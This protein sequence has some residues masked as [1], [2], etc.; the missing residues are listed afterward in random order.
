MSLSADRNLLFGIIALQ[1]QLINREQLLTG[2]QDWSFDKS[3]PLAE[4]LVLK[5][6]L[7]P[8]QRSR[9]DLLVNANLELHDNDINQSMAQVSSLATSLHS[10]LEK[11]GDADLNGTLAHLTDLPNETSAFT[12]RFKPSEP[13]AEK[14]QRFKVLRHHASGG[15][16]DVSVAEDQELHREVA[17]KEIQADK[18]DQPELRMRFIREAEITGGLEH[19]GIVPVYGLGAYPDGR[20]YYAMRF[21]RGDSLDKAIHR[22]HEAQNDPANKLTTTEIN[23]RLRR[24]LQRFI[25]VCEAMDY[26][27]SRGVL[28]RDLKPGNI[29]LGRYG[30]TLVVDWGLAKL[31]SDLPA[32]PEPLDNSGVG[33]EFSRMDTPGPLEPSENTDSNDLTK[34]GRAM[35]TLAYMSSEQAQ[36]RLDLLGAKS[37]VFGLGAILFEILTNRAPYVSTKRK[38]M[39]RDLEL[40]NLAVTGMVPS[41]RSINSKIPKPLDAICLKALA[42]EQADRYDTAKDLADDL[43]RYLADEPVLAKRDTLVERIGRTVRRHRGSFLAGTAALLM[44]T[45]GTVFG[46]LAINDAKNSA[47]ASEQEALDQKKRADQKSEEANKLAQEEHAARIENERL[48]EE[49]TRRLARFYVATGTNIKEKGDLWGA[50]N[51]YVKAWNEDP[52]QANDVAHRLRIGTTLQEAPSLAAAFFHKDPVYDAVL[53]KNGKRL[54]TLP[55]SSRAWLYD[56]EKQSAITTLDHTGIVLAAAFNHDDT[57]LVTASVDGV[58]RFWN[59]ET[60]QK[61]GES[62]AFDAAIHSLD[63]HDSKNLITLVTQKGGPYL[64]DYDKKTKTTF[65]APLT[66]IGFNAHFLKGKD[67]VVATAGNRCGLWDATQ[68][69]PIGK[70]YDYIVNETADTATRNTFPKRDKIGTA[71]SPDGKIIVDSGKPG[72]P[73]TLRFL[74]ES[75]RV[76]ELPQLFTSCN[77]FSP[78]GSKFAYTAGNQIG[79]YDLKTNVMAYLDHPRMTLQLAWHPT[80]PLLATVG[81]GGEVRV[82]DVTRKETLGPT[83]KNAISTSRIKFSSDGQ[84]LLVSDIDGGVRL[85]KP[86]SQQQ[87]LAVATNP[88]VLQAPDFDAVAEYLDDKLYTAIEYKDQTIIFRDQL[89]GKAIQLPQSAL[90]ENLRSPLTVEKYWGAS[91]DKQRIAVTFADAEKSTLL[92]DLRNSQQ[93]KVIPLKNV[94]LAHLQFSHSG[95]WVIARDRNY[96]LHLINTATGHTK[97]SLV[98]SDD[99]QHVRSFHECVISPDDRQLA[100]SIGSSVQICSIEPLRKTG[101]CTHNYDVQNVTFSRDSTL[102][103]TASSDKTARVWSMDGEPQSPQFQHDFIVNRAILSPDCKFLTTT[104][105][106]KLRVW[107]VDTGDLLFGPISSPVPGYYDGLATLYTLNGQ[108]LEL[109]TFPLNKQDAS[110]YAE[111][112][113]SHSVD[114]LAGFSMVTRNKFTSQHVE[115]SRFSAQFHDKTFVPE[116]IQ[117]S[118]FVID[119]K[120]T[121]EPSAAQKYLG[122]IVT[123]RGKIVR[124]GSTK[125]LSF[126]NFG[127]SNDGFTAVIYEEVYEALGGKPAELFANK[128]VYIVGLVRPFRGK[129]EIMIRDAS[130]IRI[131]ESIPL[132]FENS[133]KLPLVNYQKIREHV[134]QEVAVEFTVMETGNI[135]HIC[136]LNVDS[137]RE[138][139]VPVFSGTFK[140]IPG[141]SKPEEYYLNKKVRVTGKVTLY[142]ERPQ[143][144][145]HDLRQINIVG[146]SETI[147]AAKSPDAAAGLIDLKKARDH[148]GKEVAVEFTV[149][150]TGNT[151]K[152]CF[153][154]NEDDK[155]FTVPLFS[156]T[157]KSVPGGSK[158]EDFYLKKKL[159]VTGKITLYKEKPQIEVHDLSQIQVLADNVAVTPAPASGSKIETIDYKK[160]RD[161]VGREVAVE[162]NVT[163]TGSTNKVCFLNVDKNRDFSVPLFSEVFKDVPEGKKPEDYYLNKKLRVTGKVSLYKDKPQIEVHDLSQIEVLDAPAAQ[164]AEKLAAAELIDFKKARDFVGKEVAVEFTVNKT[165]NIGKICFLNAEDASD[166]TVPVFSE[167]FKDVPGGH[168]PEEYYLKRKLRVAGKISLFRDKPQIEVHDLSQ[169]TVLD[170]PAK[171]S[172][173]AKVPAITEPANFQLPHIK[174]DAAPDNLDKDVVIEGI[175]EHLKK[176]NGDY[177][178][179][180]GEYP[181]EDQLT[182][183]IPKEIVDYFPR[184]P[185]GMFLYQH[186]FVSGRIESVNNKPVIKIKQTDQLRFDRLGEKIAKAEVVSVSTALERNG[187]YLGVKGEISSVEVSELFYLVQLKEANGAELRVAVDKACLKP[188]QA[189]AILEKPGTIFY[190]KIDAERKSAPL[191]IGDAREIVAAPEK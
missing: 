118:E 121:I 16:G 28:H 169:I 155:D 168:K 135:G 42:K 123:V 62:T 101:R 139:T 52:D 158:P 50:L 175:I 144:E 59:P 142:R 112:I 117:K 65:E 74:D 134:G 147:A 90:P 41:P 60:G 190:G 6:A 8:E 40:H 179:D 150:R 171:G 178:L 122:K 22:F 23:L 184:D 63:F 177:V 7:K 85:W 189:K 69:T 84:L 95:E 96:K 151:G 19:P 131:A 109:K 46:A 32:E 110:R 136:F 154:N 174:P 102:L 2:M 15:L 24:L 187:K 14:S 11:L 33:F 129:P 124:T 66:G 119:E 133:D 107:Q 26:A 98:A 54:V 94:D 97:S 91:D 37:D 164:P 78:E 99:V 115:Y 183:V 75:Q 30:E 140:D 20:P 143:I 58:L 31:L 39:E 163:Q 25:D 38:R 127:T 45:I 61:L 51:W 27:H 47:V 176:K 126:L 93:I 161:Y 1:N 43:E 172:V 157:F 145:V 166:F 88:Q 67:I 128:D 120:N 108:K 92:I 9:L 182:I 181:A 68:R 137:N 100:Y 17:F 36:G 82:W 53:S 146:G 89:T 180:F 81:A 130:Q 35:G 29:M 132:N 191:L 34:D 148:V 44:I 103:A 87:Q 3:T 4:H 165:G 105:H 111:I 149:N 159:R 56:T 12:V 70:K 76:V 170:A 72:L 64:W 10:E 49:N 162:I 83:L 153:L 80:K 114:K 18:A 152:I 77:A 86:I 71:V 188:E 185:E 13:S 160:A 156:E 73:A 104:S 113:T 173:T 48:A 186:V 55:E 106:G 21:I 5:G 57:L 141:G 116:T 125:G 167:T 79:V 138:F